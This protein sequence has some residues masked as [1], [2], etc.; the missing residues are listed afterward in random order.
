MCSAHRSAT[1]LKR[2]AAK[3]VESNET[4]A[5]SRGP[6][7]EL[8][9][10]ATREP[11]LPRRDSAEESEDAVFHSA[12]EDEETA[13]ASPKFGLSSPE[14]QSRENSAPPT[15]IIRGSLEDSFRNMSIHEDRRKMCTSEDMIIKQPPSLP[16]TPLPSKHKII[17]ISSFPSSS[18]PSSA[19]DKEEKKPP[20]E[21]IRRQLFIPKP[22][23]PYKPL[24]PCPDSENSSLDEMKRIRRNRP[25]TAK[26]REPIFSLTRTLSSDTNTRTASAALLPHSSAAPS[27]GSDSPR[28]FCGIRK[29][30]APPAKLTLKQADRPKVAQAWYSVFNE[31]VFDGLL[32]KDAVLVW[33]SRLRK[34]AGQ[35]VFLRS[36]KEC[37]YHDNDD[38]ELEMM[39][40]GMSLTPTSSKNAYK[41]KSIELSTKILTTEDKMATT[42]LH[43]C[44][45]VAQR[46]LETEN[47]APH[48]PLFKKWAAKASCCFPQ[49]KVTTR[50]D[51]ALAQP[52]RWACESCDMV[53]G[54]YSRSIDPAKHRCGIK[55]CRGK[56]RYLGTFN[57]DGSVRRRNKQDQD[58]PKPLSKYQ[59]FVKEHYTEAFAKTG[60]HAEAMSF[61]SRQWKEE[62]KKVV[63]ID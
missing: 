13:R 58:Q 18:S 52:Y 1:R 16:L 29:S 10:L 60:S 15:E 5:V 24:T 9:T 50:H 21:P 51:F 22:S 14:D 59:A 43:E 27:V 34:T 35:A 23:T 36:N 44:C 31:V 30:K 8:W 2:T 48:G 39:M 47:D 37:S 7:P 42:L 32:P 41:L 53:Y 6:F 17:D 20:Q 57:A 28:E 3:P 4:P 12:R 62:K 49:Y 38:A 33:N 55:D 46:L 56:L 40:Q 54:R 11:G 61:L 63:G 19:S 25:A 45:H 26:P